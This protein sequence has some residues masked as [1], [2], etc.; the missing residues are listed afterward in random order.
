M[1]GKKERPLLLC[2]FLKCLHLNTTLQFTCFYF[3]MSLRGRSS[4]YFKENS[5]S[6]VHPPLELGLLP[7]SPPQDDGRKWSPWGEGTKAQDGG[8]HKRAAPSALQAFWLSQLTRSHTRNL[9]VNCAEDKYSLMDYG[10]LRAL[11][12]DRIQA[13]QSSKMR[14]EHE[15]YKIL[16]WTL[17]KSM[18]MMKH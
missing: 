10:D 1:T 18:D 5:L 11:L 3:T 17:Q 2:R 9:P 15:H 4:P 16:T 6:S 7:W 8:G 13:S 12:K 14:K